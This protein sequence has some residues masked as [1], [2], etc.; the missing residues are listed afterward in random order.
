MKTEWYH[1]RLGAAKGV[2][3]TNKN[4]LSL[5]NCMHGYN[6]KDFSICIGL[7]SSAGNLLDF[8]WRLTKEAQE[9]PD[10]EDIVQDIH[11]PFIHVRYLTR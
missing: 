2:F 4:E 11:K 9:L 6:L 7:D 8:L 5:K 10:E 1:C 3:C